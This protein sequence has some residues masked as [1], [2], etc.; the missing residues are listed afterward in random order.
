MSGRSLYESSVSR[1]YKRLCVPIG[2]GPRTPVTVGQVVEFLTQAELN[3]MS[4]VDRVNQ[5]VSEL[6]EIV[7][8]AKVLIPYIQCSMRL[9]L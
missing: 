7:L 1:P 2:V 9:C 6:K 3:M 8:A 5:N 4:L